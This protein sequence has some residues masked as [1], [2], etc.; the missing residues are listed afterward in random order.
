MCIDFRK[1]KFLW[2]I[3]IILV[4]GLI[5]IS[6]IN[7]LTSERIKTFLNTTEIQKKQDQIISRIDK[8]DGRIN[9]L[10]GNINVLRNELQELREIA[11]KEDD[12]NRID[13]HLDEIENEIAN[14][15][16]QAVQNID[17]TNI[18][19]YINNY[20]IRMIFSFSFALIT[21]QILKFT[22]ELI[23]IKLFWKKFLTKI[24]IFQRIDTKITKYFLKN[25]KK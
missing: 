22:F 9:N 23:F 20:N 14:I 8:L 18:N 1:N 17:L 3:I 13:K 5:V 15:E 11:T 19:T 21:V 7:W 25:E 16:P 6:I 24:N 2:I 12:I 4:I 10:D